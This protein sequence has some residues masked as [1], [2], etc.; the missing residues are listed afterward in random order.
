[1]ALNSHQSSIFLSHS[2]SD[3]P[4]AR[5]LAQD[6]VK[7]GVRVWIDWIRS[8][9]FDGNEGEGDE[10]ADILYKI[11]N[12]AID[13]KTDKLNT[14]IDETH[15]RVY[16]LLT[17]PRDK[18]KGLYHL[19]A[20]LDAE[21]KRAEYVLEKIIHKGRGEMMGYFSSEEAVLLTHV[22]AAFSVLIKLNAGNVGQDEF[23]VKYDAVRSIDTVTGFFE[24]S[25]RFPND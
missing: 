4:F 15:A 22:I 18:N 16:S 24:G 21:Y 3:K 11:F 20:M 1:M 23:E 19:V 2:H 14:I 7:A 9:C 8:G 5:R 6:L 17:H 10:G 13:R 25:S 12:E